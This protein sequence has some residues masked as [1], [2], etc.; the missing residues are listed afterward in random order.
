M[1]YVFLVTVETDERDIDAPT[2][3]H[4]ANEIQSNLE[5]EMHKTGITTVIVR[6]VAAKTASWI[7]E[8]VII[9]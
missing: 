5:Y 6:G 3:Q 7:L 2:A 8:N 1:R 4:I 9:G